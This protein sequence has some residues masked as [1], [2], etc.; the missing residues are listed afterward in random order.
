MK[1]LENIP[2]PILNQI[3]DMGKGL[4]KYMVGDTLIVIYDSKKDEIAAYYSGQMKQF[5][6]NYRYFMILEYMGL[7]GIEEMKYIY[8]NII[9]PN[10]GLPDFVELK[11]DLIKNK[12]GINFIESGF[13]SALEKGNAK[14]I[15]DVT[16]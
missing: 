10:M 7:D 16:R 5:V 1:D 8:N 14:K 9:I 6:P 3:K 13:R 12:K 11:D 15:D 4:D 2:E